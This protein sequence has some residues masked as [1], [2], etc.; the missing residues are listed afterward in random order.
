MPTKVLKVKAKGSFQDWRKRA[1]TFVEK[2][3]MQYRQNY[4]ELHI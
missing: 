4:V 3:K 2:V 1:G